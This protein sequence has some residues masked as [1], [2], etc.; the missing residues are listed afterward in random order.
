MVWALDLDDPSSE[1]SLVNLATSG[2]TSIGDDVATN[3][4]YAI[5]KLAATTSQNSVS[6]LTYW[7]D[8]MAVPKCN[9]GFQRETTGHGKVYDAV[10]A[11]Q[12]YLAI[13][14]DRQAVRKP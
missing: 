12:S 11:S 5:S 9:D 3:P 1:A 2:L 8:C 7:S 13:P 14:P 6:L 4:S 10:R